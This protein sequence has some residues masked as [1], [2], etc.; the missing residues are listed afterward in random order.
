MPKRA[1]G[2]RV[3]ERKHLFQMRLGRHKPAGE[4]QVSTEGG[5]SQ[6]EPSRIVALLAQ[7]EQILVR[8]L[9]QIEFAAPYM[10]TRPPIGN[11]KELRGRA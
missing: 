3:I 5:V 11:L 7:V 9:R 2:G 1:V 4:Q 10:I 8:A 6:N